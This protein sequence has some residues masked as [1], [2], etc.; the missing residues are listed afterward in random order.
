MNVSFRLNGEDVTATDVSPTTTLLDWLRETRGLTGTKEGCNEG[1]CGACSVIVTDDSGAR[2]LNACI[3]F[4]PQLGGKAIRTVEGISAPDGTLHPVQQA[5]IDHHGSQC[6]F[7]TPGFVTT[8]AANHLNGRTDHDTA[9]AGNLCRCTGYAPIIRAAKAAQSAPVPAHMHDRL[10]QPSGRNP[11]EASSHPTTLDD[12]ADWYAA[13]PDTTLIA[14]A[15]DVGLWVTKQMRDLG[16]TAFLTHVEGLRGVTVR[17]DVIT[18]GAMTTLSDLQPVMADLYPAFAELIRRYGSAQV[19]NAA[20]IGGNVANGSPIGDGPPAL[21]A[22]DATL[23][24]R[25]G[26]RTRSLP[27]AD[28]FIDYG[29]QDRQKGEFLTHITL[30]RGTDH[31]RCYKLSKRFDQDISAVCGCFWIEVA[32]GAVK[33]ARIAFGGM[34]ATPKRAPKAEAALTGQPW[35]E[36]TIRAAMAALAQDFT[37]LSDMR[38]SAAYRMEAAQNMLLRAWSE[39]QGAPSSVLEV[40]A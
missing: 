23:H 11:Q 2:P 12:F 40:R 31:L 25:H 27:I 37:P 20:T 28:F 1:D 21:I 16:Q 30:P 17:D 15:T 24:L 22:L 32:E 33:S 6:G 5:M 36:D 29:K 13:H 14:G 38:A 39:D 4:L 34:A 3:L 9:L 18:I 8:M 26:G 10:P 35:N 19:R 7:C